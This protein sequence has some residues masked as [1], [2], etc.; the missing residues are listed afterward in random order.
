[1]KKLIIKVVTLLL[2]TSVVASS[3]SLEYRQ[4]RAHR[5]DPNW[6]DGDHHDDHHDDH[7]YDNH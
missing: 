4:H 5:N 3:C 1:M 6:H 7:H 2:F